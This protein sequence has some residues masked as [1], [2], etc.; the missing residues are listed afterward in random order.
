M[1]GAVKKSWA[2]RVFFFDFDVFF[3]G[4]AIFFCSPCQRP[5]R[6]DRH[7][8]SI[9]RRRIAEAL[10]RLLLKNQ[11][12]TGLISGNFQIFELTETAV[13]RHSPALASLTVEV[14]SAAWAKPGAFSCT[15]RMQWQMQQQLFEQNRSQVDDPINHRQSA[16]QL[17]I[18]CGI[19]CR[20]ALRIHHRRDQVQ[21]QRKIFT[22][23]EMH[24]FQ[25][26]PTLSFQFRPKPPFQQ[27]PAGSTSQLKIN[28]S[29]RTKNRRNADFSL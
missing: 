12:S 14:D 25:T 28:L 21:R 2:R 10:A 22:Q 15:H 9:F 5:H 18:Q 26:T 1:P 11:N 13:K 8:V 19:W 17:F 29:I 27:D 6:C 20:V 3:F 4:T 24:G 16:Q 7:F 23:F